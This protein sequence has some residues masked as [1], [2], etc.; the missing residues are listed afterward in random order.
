MKYV[1]VTGVT[2]IYGWHFL[3]WNFFYKILDELKPGLKVVVEG[4][5]NCLVF[6]CR[7]LRIPGT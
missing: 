3:L 1:T 2:V 7:P 5:G 4:M 6:P